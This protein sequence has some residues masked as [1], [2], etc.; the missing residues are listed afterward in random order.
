LHFAGYV[1]EN[2]I[3]MVI[4]MTTAVMVVV[5]VMVVLEVVMV[6]ATVMMTIL[7]ET[8]ESENLFFIGVLPRE[9]F[10]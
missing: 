2:G 3:I 9:C 5:T 10:S 4:M 1:S 8:M 7:D 6:T